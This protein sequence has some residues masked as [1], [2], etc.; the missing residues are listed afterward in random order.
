MKSKRTSRA[1]YVAHMGKG[2]IRTKY[3]LGTMKRRDLDVDGR[4]NLKF[5]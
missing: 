1:G 5:I 4:I 3:W 2:E